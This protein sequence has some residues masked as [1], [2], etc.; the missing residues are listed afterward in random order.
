MDQIT[1]T[2]ALSEINL[3][4]KK[5]ENKKTAILN[6]LAKASHV[7]DPYEKQGGGFAANKAELQ[8]IKDLSQRLTRIRGAISQANIANH[9][10]I[11]GETKSI[12]D[13][14]TWKREISPLDTK[15]LLDLCQKTKTNLDHWSKSP[16]VYKDDSGNTHLVKFESNIDYAE[17]MKESERFSDILEKLDGQL[18]LKNATIVIDI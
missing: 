8:S 13:W 1:I 15:F 4:K 17:V 18:S 9:I 10:S 12:N 6:N 16:Q 7:P 11:L 14:L 5:I 2:E 3:I